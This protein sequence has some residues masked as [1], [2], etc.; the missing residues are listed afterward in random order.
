[1]NK[2]PKQFTE[3]GIQYSPEKSGWVKRDGKWLKPLKFLGLTYDG[4]RDTLTASTREGS[5]LSIHTKDELLN[6][7]LIG[8]KDRRLTPGSSR[9]GEGIRGLR[10]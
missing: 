8:S 2:C 5:T 6:A 3:W 4:E 10:R 7:L 9:I 1:M